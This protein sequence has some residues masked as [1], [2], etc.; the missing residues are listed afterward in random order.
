MVPMSQ[1]KI[2]AHWEW[3]LR[4]RNIVWLKVMGL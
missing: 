4:A 3:A 1:K 2:G